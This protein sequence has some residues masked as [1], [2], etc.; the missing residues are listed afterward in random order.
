MKYITHLLTASTIYF[1]HTA[2]AACPAPPTAIEPIVKVDHQFDK[3]SQ[4][5]IYT[6]TLT[7]G[8]SA[9]TT[10]WM[11]KVESPEGAMPIN[12]PSKWKM[13][14]QGP[15]TYSPSV[16]SITTSFN[17]VV[18][19]GKAEFK[20]KS[21]LGPGP[22]KFF[23]LGTASDQLKAITVNNDD[24]VA[25]V[26]PGF[27]MEE[28]DPSMAWVS[29]VVIGP[30]SANQVT[31]KLKMK[32]LKDK[33]QKGEDNEAEEPEI[34]PADDGMIEL[35]LHQA[36]GVD[37][38]AVDLSSIKFGPYETSPLSSEFLQDDKKMNNWR[39]KPS[40]K[41]FIV[42]KFKLSDVKIRCDIDKALLFK[43]NAG[44][45]KLVG[46]VNIKPKVCD[47]K[48]MEIHSGRLKLDPKYYRPIQTAH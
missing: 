25:P 1:A 12:L 14:F 35:I 43:A 3:K 36:E 37:L 33:P 11:F 9:K 46:A 32:L 48:L 39:N 26:C 7:N 13:R 40:E 6:Y 15:P 19:G 42:M 24:E 27:F 47:N 44:D 34:S 28:I 5:H 8:P 22:T 41:K 20:L 4:D 2:L 18:P 30:V 23:S 17:K 38:S 31:A 21:K 10:I 29:G 16:I 45:K